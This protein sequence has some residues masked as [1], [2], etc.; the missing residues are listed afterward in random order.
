MKGNL[1]RLFGDPLEGL[2][3]VLKN[4]LFLLL[5]LV[6][7]ACCQSAWAQADDENK[8]R[9][10]R[11]LNHLTGWSLDSNG[12]HP[13][14]YMLLENISGRDLSG[15]TIKMQGKFTDIH[16]T[17]PSTAKT[18]IRR[19]LKPHQQF[20]IALL[21]PQG[22][23]LPRDP[24]F[25]PVMDCK[26]MMRVGTVGDEGT[27]YLLVTKIDSVT[28]TQEDSFQKL[29]EV[30]SY[31]RSHHQPASS[32]HFPSHRH[33]ASRTPRTSHAGPNNKQEAP[34]EPLVATAG[35]LS[36]PPAVPSGKTKFELLTDKT[37]PGLGSDFYDFEKTLGMPAV[38][39]AKKKDFTW[40]RY[41]HQPSGTDIVIASK[42][43]TGKADL[44]AFLV[45]KTE[46][47]PDQKMIERLRVFAGA[48]KAAKLSGLSKSVRYLPTG[49]L[50]LATSSAPGLKI[51]CMSV[52]ESADHAA[53]TL[54]MITRLPN[55]PSELIRGHS[56]GNEVLKT[57][58]LHE[59]S[60]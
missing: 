33:P 15:I 42:E 50:E 28:A 31:D 10:L 41:R 49:R 52:P 2:Q 9:N 58:P 23:E 54:V 27:E 39:D 37:M 3:E 51:M 44:I 34:V 59:S 48:N 57:L 16:T 43:R 40:A 53:G 26:V 55:D 29:N 35:K 20:P 11:V 32:T 30:T 18:E 14:V 47:A 25:W 4:F 24:N 12:Y 22:F 21:A 17:E 7:Q 1:H 56:G 36:S 19:A 5:P 60:N 46:A 6:L 8:P 45:P 13:A 38:T